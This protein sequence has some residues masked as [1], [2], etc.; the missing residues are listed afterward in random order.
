MKIAKLIL[1]CLFML[2]FGSIM[3]VYAGGDEDAVLIDDK[4]YKIIDGNID[5]N[6]F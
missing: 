4:P 5:K 3:S 1:K 6:T 2:S